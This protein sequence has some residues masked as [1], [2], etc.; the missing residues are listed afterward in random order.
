M[1]VSEIAEQLAKNP[2]TVFMVK[3]EWGSGNVKGRI[4]EVTTTTIGGDSWRGGY[5]GRTVTAYKVEVMERDYNDSDRFAYTVKGRSKPVLPQHI[6]GVFSDELTL[7]EE[8]ERTRVARHKS[9]QVKATI[10]A[11]KDALIDHIVTTVQRTTNV[12]T[13]QYDYE[14]LWDSTLEALAKTLGY[15]ER[16]TNMLDTDSNANDTVA[17]GGN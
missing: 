4:V 16:H 8:C 14:K 10:K 11:R 2:S 7:E 17:V 5:G 13:S 1:K 6:R 15:D 9:V 3:E 12:R